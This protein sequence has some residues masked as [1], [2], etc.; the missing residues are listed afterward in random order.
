MP[1]IAESV[2][3]VRGTREGF[4]I[5]VVACPG[6]DLDALRETGARWAM[7]AFWPGH[8]VNQVLRVIDRGKPD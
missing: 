6:E 2:A 8:R 5:A 4:D 1:P 7:H 3:A